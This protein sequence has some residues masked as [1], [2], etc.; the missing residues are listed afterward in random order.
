[1]NEGSQVRDRYNFSFELL[2]SVTDSLLL[3]GR[4]GKE[5]AAVMMMN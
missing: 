2:L 3:Q 5:D 4:W 1:M